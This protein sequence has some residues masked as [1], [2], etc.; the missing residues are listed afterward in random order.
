MSSRQEEKEQ[1]KQER[2]QREA[3]AAA[4]AKRKRLLQLIGGVVVACVIVA[5]VIFAISGGGGGGGDVDDAKLAATAK[6]A[7]CVYRSFPDEGRGHTADDRTAADYKTNPPTSGTHNPNP[8]GDGLY[9]AGNEPEI[10]NWVHTL[11]HGRILLQYKP[12]TDTADVAQL[13]TLF[14][15]NVAGSGGAY[16]SVL[17][18]NNSKMQAQVAAVAW[19]HSMT[20]SEFTPRTIDAFRTF[21]EALIDKGPEVV[22]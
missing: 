21:R 15:E 2:L 14:N 9:V 18:Q 16:H 11:E 4:A 17:M 13:T 7:G 3:A 19:R 10:A 12:G 5:G 6:T 22:P 1:R 8:A 20:C